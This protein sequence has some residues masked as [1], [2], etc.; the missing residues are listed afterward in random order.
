V[1]AGGGSEPVW[2]RDGRELFYRTVGTGDPQLMSAVIET[3]PSLRVVSRTPLFSVA[4]Y[5]P[6]VPHA[7]YDVMPGG[8]SFVMVRQGRLAE[9]VYV[10]H[11]TEQH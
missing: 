9:F 4:D 1:S 5:E 2:S 7:N 11:W 8:R 3:S 10:Q 6:A